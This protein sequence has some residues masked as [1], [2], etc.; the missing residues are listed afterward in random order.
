MILNTVYITNLITLKNLGTQPYRLIMY[1]LSITYSNSKR[2]QNKKIKDM[3]IEMNVVASQIS[4]SLNE[5]INNEIVI[6]TNGDRYLNENFFTENTI[7]PNSEILL[8]FMKEKKLQTQDY[9][10]LLYILSI[11]DSI[12]MKIEKQKRKDT[13]HI[14]GI[15]E[16]QISRSNKRL[17]INK[18]IYDKDG[19]YFFNRNFFRN[20]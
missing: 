12:T 2:I 15:N 14:T 1:L 7:L 19:N 13:S 17:L 10:Y 6:T 9:R 20:E 4:V 16:A 8:K 3:S 11:T 18:V 5:L